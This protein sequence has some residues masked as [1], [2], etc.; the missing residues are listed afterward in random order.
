[1]LAST[2]TLPAYKNTTPAPCTFPRD[3]SQRL[4]TSGKRKTT[5]Y[6]FAMDMKL[7]VRIERG[8]TVRIYQIKIAPKN[9]FQWK[10]KDSLLNRCDNK[11]FVRRLKKLIH[12]FYIDLFKGWHCLWFPVCFSGFLFSRVKTYPSWHVMTLKWRR[13]NVD[14][15]WL[16]RIDVNTKSFWHQMSTGMRYEWK[17]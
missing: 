16:R 17:C 3:Y 9:L 2:K 13:I 15:T 14:V 8:H 7:K 11:L 12:M 1:M 5:Q 4:E 10:Q 6:V